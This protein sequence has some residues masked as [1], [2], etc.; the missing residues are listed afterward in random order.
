[1]QRQVGVFAAVEDRQ[2]D[3]ASAVSASSERPACLAADRK[4][5]LEAAQDK[6]ACSEDWPGERQ[7][8]SFVD[9]VN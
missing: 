7:E 3:L 8:V 9:K 1:M 5:G 6:G 2:P 4:R